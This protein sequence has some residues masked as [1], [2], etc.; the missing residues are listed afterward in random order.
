MFLYVVYFGNNLSTW[1]LSYMTRKFVHLSH[2]NTDGRPENL[3]TALLPF[4]VSCPVTGFGLLSGNIY[5]NCN[6]FSVM[7]VFQ[8]HWLFWMH[9]LGMWYN[10]SSTRQCTRILTFSGCANYAITGW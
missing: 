4:S 3:S 10:Y 6:K 8:V 5:K 7:H 1:S 2:T 9:M